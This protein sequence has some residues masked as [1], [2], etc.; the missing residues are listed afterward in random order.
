MGNYGSFEQFRQRYPK[1]KRSDNTW[2]GRLEKIARAIPDRTAFIQGERELTW[3]QFIERVNQLANAFLD[4]GIKKEDRV[5]IM[6]FN[7]I[8]WMETYFAASRIGAVPVNVNP[9][10]VPAELKYLLEDSDSV[11]LILEEDG[12]ERINQ[13]RHEL[14]LLKH[15]IVLGGKAPTG[16]L[17]YDE[18]I[19]KYPNS[20]PE[21]SW[22]VTN[23][24]FAFLFY[25]RGTTGYPKGTI[26]D[27]E[28]RVRGL[29]IIMVNAMAPSGRSRK[30]GKETTARG[31]NEDAGILRMIGVRH[32]CRKKLL[33][34]DKYYFALYC[35]RQGK[36]RL[37]QFLAVC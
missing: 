28:T 9:R 27:G 12:V 6:G 19:S 13:I 7:S 17:S 10:F 23:E 15:C 31:G 22:K 3:S 18:L 37:L 34:L 11:A 20:K 33:F 24:D 26:W 1:G 36:V 30:A 35:F 25:T 2:G 5:A 4:L 29:D 16:M 14:P 32:S 21:L 8:E